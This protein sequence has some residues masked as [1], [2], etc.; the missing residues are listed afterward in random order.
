MS[1]T[2]EVCQHMQLIRPV[3]IVTDCKGKYKGKQRKL[4]Q[5]ALLKKE[6]KTAISIS[7][8]LHVFHGLQSFKKFCV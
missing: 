6:R 2:D 4:L 1:H 7:E 8:F 5:D 3:Q